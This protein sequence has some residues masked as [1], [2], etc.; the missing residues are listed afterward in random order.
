MLQNYSKFGKSTTTTKRESIY[1]KSMVIA[2][3]LSA[4]TVGFAQNIK[5]LEASNAGLLTPQVVEVLSAPTILIEE[6]AAILDH[7]TKVEANTWS[8]ISNPYSFP[9]SAD[10]FLEKNKNIIDATVYIPNNVTADKSEIN[11]ADGYSTYNLSG[12]AASVGTLESRSTKNNFDKNIAFGIIQN[13]QGMLVQPTQSE[14]VVI[15]N[16]MGTETHRDNVLWAGKEPKARNRYWMNLT[17]AAG[18]FSQTLMGYFKD[19]TDDIDPGFDGAV[20]TG[21]QVTLY[22]FCNGQKLGIQGQAMPLHNEKYVVF[23]YNTKTAG[24]LSLFIP[25]T[26]LDFNNV[27]PL[28]LKD[29]VLGGF[30]MIKDAPYYFYS[31]AGTFDERFE[32]HYTDG[33]GRLMGDKDT[34][35]DKTIIAYVEGNSIVVKANNSLYTEIEIYD[36][37]AKVVK[38]VRDVKTDFSIIDGIQQQNQLLL[39]N[40][41]T[42]EGKYITKKIIF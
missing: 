15:S 26:E 34:M 2:T 29:G 13:G 42:L 19:A 14:D 36:I 24:M 9:I 40:V 21:G 31:P 20:F 32:I 41:K 33:N 3:L 23:G 28:L 35:E 11:Y 12:G 39:V 4:S 16:N 17:N 22:S 6:N 30:H 27:M 37:N 10:D 5:Q 8:Y 18:N 25:Q 1:I 7:K 38:A